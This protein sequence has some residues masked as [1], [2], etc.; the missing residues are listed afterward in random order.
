MAIMI[1]LFFRVNYHYYHF[2]YNYLVVLANLPGMEIAALSRDRPRL[3]RGM[4]TGL[5]TSQGEHGS[6][7]Y[8][9]GNIFFHVTSMVEVLHRVV[10]GGIHRDLCQEDA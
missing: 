4:E 7:P 2:F 5:S 8:D 1:F 3:I 6:S 9:E 10:S